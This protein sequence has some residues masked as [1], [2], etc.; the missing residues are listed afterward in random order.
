[1]GHSWLM[2][3]PTASASSCPTA[4]HIGPLAIGNSS[5]GCFQCTMFSELGEQS[6][7]VAEND[8]SST[9]ERH[10]A[11]WLAGDAALSALAFGNELSGPKTS[12]NRRPHQPGDPLSARQP[13]PRRSR[14]CGCVKWFVA[15]CHECCTGGPKS[16]PHGLTFFFWHV[17]LL[18]RAYG[19]PFVF[20]PFEARPRP[21]Q[22]SCSANSSISPSKGAVV[23][24]CRASTDHGL[25][26]TVP[27]PCDA[28]R[29]D[30]LHLPF[31]TA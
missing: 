7:S 13:H 28:S 10:L 15:L 26:T 3:L 29:S 27:K 24:L 6:Q 12:Q 5:H 1:M 25:R 30:V 21:K 14:R 2:A 31:S 19:R 8:H 22:G 9:G 23:S 18:G 17:L 11:R 4:G 16:S 20:S